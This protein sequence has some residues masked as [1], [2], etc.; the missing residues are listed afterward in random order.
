MKHAIISAEADADIDLIAEYTTNTWGW[1]Q[2]DRY[3][4]QL[5]DS[6]QILAENPG[7]GRACDAISS[8]LRRHELGRIDICTSQSREKLLQWRYVG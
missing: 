1:R 2:T 3:L 8:G 4:S 7:I 6:F 5:E